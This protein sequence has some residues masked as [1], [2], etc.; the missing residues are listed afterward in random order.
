MTDLLERAEAKRERKAVR[1]D[2]TAAAR[3]SAS[4]DGAA[5]RKR[6]QSQSRPFVPPGDD[7]D[8]KP[9][10]RHRGKKL[11]LMAALAAGLGRLPERRPIRR[12]TISRLLLPRRP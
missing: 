1:G 10:K 2:A 5:D 4:A 8:A 12:S 11:E 3:R 9:P 7:P 6:W